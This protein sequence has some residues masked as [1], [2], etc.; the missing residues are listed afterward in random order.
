MRGTYSFST[1]EDGLGD[2]HYK[3]YITVPYITQ[4]SYYLT[5]RYLLRIRN[6]GLPYVHTFQWCLL[7]VHLPQ[8]EE[9]RIQKIR[10]RPPSPAVKSRNNLATDVNSALPACYPSKKHL[11]C[12]EATWNGSGSEGRIHA[13]GNTEAMV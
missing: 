13:G 1:A 5:V 2:T 11:I 3:C 10:K 9:M 7:D 8:K 4:V 6:L 12:S